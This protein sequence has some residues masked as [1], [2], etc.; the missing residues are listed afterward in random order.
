MPKL[1][2]VI[3]DQP[4]TLNNQT[5]TVRPFDR[6]KALEWISRVYPLSQVK[7]YFRTLPADP[8]AAQAG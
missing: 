4:Y 7:V 6:W 1:H 5:Y 3:V 2:L 8:G